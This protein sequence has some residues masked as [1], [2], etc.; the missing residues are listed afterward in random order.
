MAKGRGKKP[1][2]TTIM[3]LVAASSLKDAPVT[4]SR[5]I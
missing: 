4:S 2:Q 3:R 1:S 5:M